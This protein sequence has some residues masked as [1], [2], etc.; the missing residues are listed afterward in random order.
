MPC[1][2]KSSCKSTKAA[3]PTKPAKAS[4]SLTA[5][6]IA[7]ELGVTGGKV[8]KAIEKLGLAP[9]EKKGVCSYYARS[10]VGKIKAALD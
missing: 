8:K 10:A 4:D 3:K 2:P 5:G 9:V 7:E 1:K 6:K